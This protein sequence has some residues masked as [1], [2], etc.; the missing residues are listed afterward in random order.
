LYR[1]RSSLIGADGIGRL[2]G[3]ANGALVGALDELES[4]GFVERSRT[5]RGVRLYHF[6]LPAD[7]ARRDA[8]EH[9]NRLADSR[10]GRLRLIEALR[11]RPQTPPEGE[12]A[13]RSLG[14]KAGTSLPIAKEQS[15]PATKQPR[16]GG[17]K[18]EGG[19]RWRK[20]S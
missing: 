7:A 15:A 12:Q 20:V 2:L 18:E 3:F 1:H 9:L 4:L 19:G 16:P 13:A 11:S 17:R 6:V 8:F 14:A 10:A 5:I